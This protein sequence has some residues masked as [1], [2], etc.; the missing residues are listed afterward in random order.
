MASSS[1]KNYQKLNST[2]ASTAIYDPE[3]EKISFSSFEMSQFTPT[4]TGSSEFSSAY[5]SPEVSDHKSPSWLMAFEK[6]SLKHHVSEFDSLDLSNIRVTMPPSDPW[7]DITSDAKIDDSLKTH[8][9][10]SANFD[11]FR[12]PLSNCTNTSTYS[13]TISDFT[14][15]ILSNTIDERPVCKYLL[16]VLFSI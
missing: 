7:D 8:N 15:S 14:Y 13:T 12:L 11:V 5:I 6:L 16:D 3:N 1:S 4:S 10:N 9:S 2:A